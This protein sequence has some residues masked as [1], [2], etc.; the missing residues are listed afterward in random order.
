ME[1][2][3]KGIIKEQ[4]Q[5]QY[6]RGRKQTGTKRKIKEGKNSGEV[7]KRTTKGWEKK[8]FIRENKKNKNNNKE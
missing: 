1:R 8:K 4:Q 7:E 6:K 5:L 2:K 3:K